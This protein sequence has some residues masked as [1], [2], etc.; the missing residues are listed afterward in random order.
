MPLQTRRAHLASLIGA[1][2]D[3][4]T[5]L[6]TPAGTPASA[7]IW[8]ITNAVSGVSAAGFRMT[9]QPAASAGPSFRVAIAA[10]KFQGVT[11]KETP[12]G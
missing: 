2:C 11:R 8:A 3:E 10:G 1:G 7:M 4:V 6:T 5:T 9:V 12:I